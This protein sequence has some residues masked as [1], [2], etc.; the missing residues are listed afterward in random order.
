MDDNCQ[1]LSYTLRNMLTWCITFWPYNLRKLV[2]SFGYYT[3][4]LLNLAP[5]S[6]IMADDNLLREQR[7]STPPS[8]LF[9]ARMFASIHVQYDNVLS[10]RVQFPDAHGVIRHNC[11]ST[12]C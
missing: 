8:H 9:A 2:T 6:P 5:D 12:Q 4:S 10:S 7:M 11:V 3:P 1:I